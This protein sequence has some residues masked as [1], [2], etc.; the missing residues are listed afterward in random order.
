[1]NLTKQEAIKY[2]RAMWIWIA[3]EIARRNKTVS[4]KR[5]KT[6]S[7]VEYKAKYIRDIMGLS[8]ND[9]YDN[10]F[11]CEYVQEKR[12]RG[13]SD[14]PVIWGKDKE[15]TCCDAEYDL[16]MKCTNWKEQKKLAYKIAMLPER[17]HV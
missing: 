7:I 15:K 16:V 9:V 6:A 4:A 14:C 17:E 2:H 5:K 12:E 10:C 3:R 1:M 13:C 11:C 8:V